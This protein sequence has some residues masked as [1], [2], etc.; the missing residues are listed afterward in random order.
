[1]S[2]NHVIGAIVALALLGAPLATTNPFFHHM[3]IMVL[4]S[5]L[6]GVA[7]NLLGGYSGQ[8]SFGHSA[9]L[10]VGA[11]ATMLL[12]LKLGGRPGSAW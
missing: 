4:F 12:H 10:G 3:L 2:K 9:F 11:Y 1:M 6:L 7:W 8:V 5:T